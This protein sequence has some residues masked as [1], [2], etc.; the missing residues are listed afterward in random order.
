MSSSSRSG[1]ALSTTASASATR[2]GLEDLDVVELG[3]HLAKH[4]P[5]AAL[6]VDDQ[7]LHAT[8]ARRWRSSCTVDR[9][10]ADSLAAPTMS[11]R[12]PSTDEER[13]AV[14]GARA[15]IV[16]PCARTRR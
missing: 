6:V 10:L 13:P 5:G 3:E 15:S 8:F 11:R 16:Q 9:P 12:A 14:R 2:A 4:A 7:D 1:A